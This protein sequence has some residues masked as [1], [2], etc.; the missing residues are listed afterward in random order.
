MLVQSVVD[1][2]ACVWVPK[3]FDCIKAF[4]HRAMR[5]FLGVHKKTTHSAVREDGM[6]PARGP[7]ECVCHKVVLR[8]NR[9][10]LG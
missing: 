5:F 4:Q 10:N 9:M 8:Y 3:G 1:N 7:S 6:D 2:G